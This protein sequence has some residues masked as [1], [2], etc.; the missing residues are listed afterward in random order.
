VSIDGTSAA[1]AF[2]SGSIAG[3][4]SRESVSP[5]A[6]TGLIMAYAS[7]SGEPGED[8]SFGIGL[9]DLQRVRDR[10]D[11]Y[12]DLA[13]AGYFWHPLFQEDPSVPENS[14]L[15]VSVQNHGTLATW[16]IVVDVTVNGQQVLYDIESLA[17]GQTGSVITVLTLQELKQMPDC[18]CADSPRMVLNI[19]PD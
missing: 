17:P 15:A 13:V 9:V 6:A 4:M 3:I 2:V 19:I 14:R 11:N 7:D 1:A 18:I 16:N 10:Y 12:V 5:A 8:P